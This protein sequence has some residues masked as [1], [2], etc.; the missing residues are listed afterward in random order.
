[1][2]LI[3]IATFLSGLLLTKILLFLHV[4]K[5]VIRYPL[6]VLFAYL[7]FFVFIK[8]WLWY[9]SASSKS[10]IVET[11]G[12][13]TGNVV[14]VPSLP[15]GESSVNVEPFSSGGGNF[16]GGGASNTFEQIDGAAYEPSNEILNSA[17]SIADSSGSDAVTEVASGVADFDEGGIILIILGLIL[18]VI[19]GAG[20]YLLYQAPVILAEVAFDFLL[21]TSLIKSSKKID[22]PDWAGSVFRATWIPFLLVLVITLGFALFVSSIYPEATRLSDVLKR[23]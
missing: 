8:I 2:S 18:A 6:A 5:M 13:V 10:N 16:G 21:A 12:D 1:M 19:F 14:D 17:G 4:E 3:L 7:S 15:T 11:A 23:C 20:I 22:S 9:V